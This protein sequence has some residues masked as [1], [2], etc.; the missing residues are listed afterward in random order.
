MIALLRDVGYRF[1]AIRQVLDELVSGRFDQIRH[2]LD[3]RLETLNQTT[4]LCIT[5]TS[6]LHNY[7]GSALPDAGRNR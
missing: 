1:D 4:W 2:A 6:T 3:E 7:L 5:A